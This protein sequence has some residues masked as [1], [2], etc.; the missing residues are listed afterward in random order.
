[1]DW[2][3]ERVKDAAGIHMSSF[4]SDTV[5]EEAAEGIH[6]DKHSYANWTAPAAMMDK[7]REPLPA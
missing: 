1:M 3:F 7:W 4:K 5:D 6:N 2:M